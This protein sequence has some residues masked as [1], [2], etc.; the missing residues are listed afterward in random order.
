MQYRILSKPVLMEN[1]NF[2]ITF[3]GYDTATE[4]EVVCQ[5]SINFHAA[6]M[7]E[8]M[9]EWKDVLIE[10]DFIPGS[11]NILFRVDNIMPKAEYTLHRN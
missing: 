11:G 5:T 7:L 9:Q 8:K 1:D 2:R 4:R 3:T 6:T 10:G